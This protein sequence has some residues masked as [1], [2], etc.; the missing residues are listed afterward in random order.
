MY[1][2]PIGMRHANLLNYMRYGTRHHFL[3]FLI[4]VISAIHF[5]NNTHLN[6]ICKVKVQNIL[7]IEVR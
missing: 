7:S 1:A 5:K 4:A 2:L 6:I 3:P